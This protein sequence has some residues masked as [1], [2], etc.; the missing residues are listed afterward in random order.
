MAF[1]C[2]LQ[3]HPSKQSASTLP[4][5]QKTSI[6]SIF[7]ISANPPLSLWRQQVPAPCVPP[8]GIPLLFLH[9]LVPLALQCRTLVFGLA[10][11]LFR[12]RSPRR[13][14]MNLSHVLS[15]DTEHGLRQDSLT[16]PCFMFLKV[17][18]LCPE[19][20]LRCRPHVGDRPARFGHD[21]GASI[22]QSVAIH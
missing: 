3:Y 8:C 11:L 19:P 4:F 17:H 14:I 5:I 7:L 20:C 12:H 13:T 21:G 15:F 22:K 1:T 18:F 10:A 9:F 16:N 6:V 2:A